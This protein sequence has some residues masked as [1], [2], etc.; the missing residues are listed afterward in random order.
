VNAACKE[1]VGDLNL[2]EF[3][4]SNYSFEAS[5]LIIMFNQD[6]PNDRS[7][8]EKRDQTASSAIARIKP[9]VP[10]ILIGERL[11]VR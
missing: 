7:E 6:K 9:E 2:S 1:K 5:S 11:V 10:P 3:P 8:L 4:I